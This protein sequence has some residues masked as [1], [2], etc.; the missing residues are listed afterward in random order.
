M[1][2]ADKSG[3]DVGCEELLNPGAEAK[4]PNP[5][6]LLRLAPKSG[7]V[8]VM[9]LPQEE[10]MLTGLFQDVLGD[11]E[12]AGPDPEDMDMDIAF[13]DIDLLIK[14]SVKFVGVGCAGFGAF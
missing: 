9:L 14:V 2:N 6:W 10:L 1:S 3:L 4:F 7:L 13:I 12:L 8:L 11:G 5:C